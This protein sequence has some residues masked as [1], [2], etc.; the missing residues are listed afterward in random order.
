MTRQDGMPEARIIDGKALAAAI[1][2]R[3]AEQVADLKRQG[4]P[5]RL[6]AVMVGDPEAGS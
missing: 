3:T 1:K 5:V 4:I 6:D 2:A